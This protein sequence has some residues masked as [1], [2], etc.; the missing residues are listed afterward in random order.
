MTVSR[1]FPLWFWFNGS[2]LGSWWGS[3][4]QELQDEGHIYSWACIAIRVTTTC[5]AAIIDVVQMGGA[6]L[7]RRSAFAPQFA[8]VAQN[9][10]SSDDFSRDQDRFDGD[11]SSDLVAL[12]RGARAPQGVKPCGIRL[13]NCTPAHGAW[14][15]RGCGAA[16]YSAPLES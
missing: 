4:E 5:A 3:Q 11:R 16:W 9:R 13:S 7:P 8:E 14:D 6:L 2:A 10:L 1:I 12:G 15:P